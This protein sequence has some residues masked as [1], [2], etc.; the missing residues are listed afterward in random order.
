VLAAV[1]PSLALVQTPRG[2]TT[3]V[4]IDGGYV[5]AQARTVWP[6]G[7]VRLAFPGDDDSFDAPVL[8]WDLLSDIAVIGPVAVDAPAASTAPA[9]TFSD[10]TALFRIGYPEASRRSPSISTESVSGTYKW[11][12]PG[13]TYLLTDP[14]TGG[15]LVSSAGEVVGLALGDGYAASV[16]DAE[17][18]A[19]SLIEGGQAAGNGGLVLGAA[20]LE[21]SV[22]L[23]S[24]SRSSAFILTDPSPTSRI[25]VTSEVD[26]ALDVVD[27]TCEL[28]LTV[29]NVFRWR[30]GCVDRVRKR[31]S[32]LRHRLPDRR[33]FG[34][35]PI[36]QQPS[37]PNPGRR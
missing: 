13:L 29:D 31:G 16:A 33:R 6:Y 35:S 23:E 9:D 14:G 21:H 5:V 25:L 30:R 8:G 3:G 17:A 10:G 27:V 20:G 7:R 11:V 22:D 1:A 36:D 18:V 12:G 4:L 15:V 26:V 2:L 32:V 37:R 24:R 34:E 19:R 28:V